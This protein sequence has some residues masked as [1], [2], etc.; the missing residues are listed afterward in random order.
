MVHCI[1]WC[2]NS[3]VFLTSLEAFGSKNI[4][5]LVSICWGYFRRTF[6][7][8]YAVMLFSFFFIVSFWKNRSQ[9]KNKSS[10]H[11]VLV[12]L[13]SLFLTLSLPFVSFPLVF[14]LVAFDVC[15]HACY[16]K[17]ASKQKKHTI[18][19]IL[20]SIVHWTRWNEM[21]SKAQ[22]HRIS[23]KQTILYGPFFPPTAV[24][25]KCCFHPFQQHKRWHACF[26]SS[27]HII[28]V[29]FCFENNHETFSFGTSHLKFEPHF[30]DQRCFWFVDRLLRHFY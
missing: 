14:G 3:F 6:F 22:T 27:I 5:Y 19:H 17:Q 12:S 8:H 15:L 24:V 13:Y 25:C 11:S 4:I 21:M 1:L 20:E 9:F 29:C 2:A 28:V 26:N 23:C 10:M 7:I 16:G 30:M 18:N